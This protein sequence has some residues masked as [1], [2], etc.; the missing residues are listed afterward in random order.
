MFAIVNKGFPR[1]TRFRL[2]SKF[3]FFILLLAGT[4]YWPSL[5]LQILKGKG[6]PKS[7]LGDPPSVIVLCLLKNV[8][9]AY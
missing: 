3:I 1:N 5:Q 8:L 2:F 4:L 9:V 6:V 7:C